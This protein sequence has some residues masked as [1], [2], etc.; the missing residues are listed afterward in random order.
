MF[1]T[2]EKDQTTRPHK[3]KNKTKQ[4]NQHPVVAKLIVSDD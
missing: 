3:N 4:I 1:Y 2:N